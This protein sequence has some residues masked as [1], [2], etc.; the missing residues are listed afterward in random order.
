MSDIFADLDLVPIER[1][2]ADVGKCPRTVLRWI[3]RPGGLPS[4]KIGADRFVHL[5]SAKTWIMSQL[6]TRHPEHRGHARTR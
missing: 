4:V 1:F 5:A 2:A 6:E 3:D